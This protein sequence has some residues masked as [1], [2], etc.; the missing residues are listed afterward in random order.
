M[1]SRHFGPTVRYCIT[2]NSKKVKKVRQREVGVILRDK[3]VFARNDTFVLRTC[4]F[5]LYSDW[6]KLEGEY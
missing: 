1:V 2:Y 6:E 3:S 4:T 5:L